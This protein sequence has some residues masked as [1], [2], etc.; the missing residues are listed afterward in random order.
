MKTKI[1]IKNSF[2]R[3]LS[4]VVEWKDLKSDFDKKFESVKSNY[5]PAGGR[6]GKV[7]GMALDLFKKNYTASIEAQFAEDSISKYYQEGV[8]EL[9]LVPINQGKIIDMKFK[10][11]QNLELEIEFEIKPE[12]KLPKYD[13]KFKVTAAKYISSSLSILTRLNFGLNISCMVSERL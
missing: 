11:E 10:S 12:F 7:Q 3:Q 9:D 2:T 4:I 6:K 5:T 13:K 8:K 1:K